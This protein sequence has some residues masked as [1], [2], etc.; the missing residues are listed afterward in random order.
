MNLK[1][2]L[3]TALSFA[4]FYY[5]DIVEL[6]GCFILK[7]KFSEKLYQSWKNECNGEKTCIEKMINLYQLR[8][9][10][11]LNT[12]DDGNLEEQIR[13]LGDVLKLFWSMSFKERF[14]DRV[15]NVKVFDEDGELFITVFEEC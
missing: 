10:F 12:E 1:S 3:Q 5:P 11:H 6:D 13:V 15:F 8:D 9:F 2:D 14:P 7:D 4:K